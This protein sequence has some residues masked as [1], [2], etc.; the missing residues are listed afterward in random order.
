[1]AYEAKPGTGSL[2]KNDKKGNDKAPDYRGKVLDPT[3]KEWELSAWV[4]ESASGT[5]YMSLS[6]KEPYR[7]EQATD[8][9]PPVS[10]TPQQ[11]PANVPVQD[12]LPF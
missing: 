4:R 7:K 12:D 1:M 2:F 10:A 8:G 5:K 9:P 6:C 11:R 3:G